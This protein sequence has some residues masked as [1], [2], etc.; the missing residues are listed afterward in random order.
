MLTADECDKLL[1]IPGPTPVVREIL[2]ALSEPTIS[3]MSPALAE[4]VTRCLSGIRNVAETDEARVFVFGGSGT[5]AQ[6][7]AVVNLVG[8]G[9][10]LLVASN[11]FFGDRFVEMAK[12]HGIDVHRVA[13]RWG[14][15]VTPDELR[16]YL[17]KADFR[18]VTLTQ[19]DTST[20]TL[21][22]VGE[23]ATVAREAGA[24]VIVDA[25]C[26]LGG[27]PSRMGVTAI[28]I[29]LS[30]AQKALGVPPGLAILAVS[31]RGLERRRAMG[32]VAA[33]YIDLL[34]WLKSMDDPTTYFSTHAVNL[35]Y[36]LSAALDII[37][38]EGLEARFHR[39]ARLARAFRLG[40]EVT[41][42][43]PLT[44]ERYLAP[45]LSVL[46]YPDGVDDEKFRTA[47]GRRGVVAAACLGPW[48]G[49][50]ARF[51]HMGNITETE[52]LRGLAAIEGALHD[53]G[54]RVESGGSLAA[55]QASMLAQPTAP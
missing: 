25:V 1:M 13:A 22:P 45:T 19:V 38:A 17:G 43:L 54:A 46:A 21:A 52:I 3:H 26:A 42:F 49:L 9:E 23:L 31:E 44:D 16:E 34:N 18:A 47:L 4:I 29:L 11:G 51:G 8:P 15:S 55:A 7:A 10:R 24:L 2:D 36:A 20:G 53:V 41:G 14:E 37:R 27:I 30:G 50:G 32:G 12:P 48:K 6:E 33:Y 40:A 28:D 5:L 39:H 35:F